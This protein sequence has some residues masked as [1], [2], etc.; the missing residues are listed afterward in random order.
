MSFHE[1]AGRIDA[2]H[3][4]TEAPVESLRARV[5]LEDA[6][7]DGFSSH[8]WQLEQLLQD[9]DDKLE[10]LTRSANVLPSSGGRISK[11]WARDQGS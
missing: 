8:V 5:N 6:Q 7:A 1:N 10:R 4:E 11:R 3:H 9:V 2:R